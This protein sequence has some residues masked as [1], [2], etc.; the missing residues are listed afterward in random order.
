MRAYR[1]I[2][3][4]N[5]R[6]SASILTLIA[7]IL[8]WHRDTVCSTGQKGRRRSWAQ[9][10]SRVKS[11]KKRVKKRTKVLFQH[12]ICELLQVRGGPE[13][14]KAIM[15]D[16]KRGCIAVFLAYKIPKPRP[17]STRAHTW[18]RQKSFLFERN[19]RSLLDNKS[20]QNDSHQS[21]TCA[22]SAKGRAG[23]K[24]TSNPR[25]QR[26]AMIRRTW[27]ACWRACALSP[28]HRCLMRG[29]ELELSFVRKTG[30]KDK[31]RSPEQPT[32]TSHT[33]TPPSELI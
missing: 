28:S 31:R 11:T 23:I 1:P 30:E 33:P 10:K 12:T 17:C 9:A 5:A 21:C 7:A 26:Y 6:T 3:A 19:R 32:P 13:G 22:T 16:E 15:N 4:F 24:C 18:H 14:W 2:A 8:I 25:D 20:S 29:R 27:A